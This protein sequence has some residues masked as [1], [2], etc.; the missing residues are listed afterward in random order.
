MV[1]ARG[2]RTGFSHGAGRYY[3]AAREADAAAMEG[4]R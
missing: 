1:I 2:S 4:D 3:S